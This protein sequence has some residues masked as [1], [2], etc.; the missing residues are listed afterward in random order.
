[1]EKRAFLAVILSIAVF[2]I[3]SMVFGP[4]KKQLP[5]KAFQNATSAAA[6]ANRQPSRP[7]RR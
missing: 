3:F 2:Y 6:T 1:M 4:A 7:R 5:P